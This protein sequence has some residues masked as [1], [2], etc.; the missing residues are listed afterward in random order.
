MY[1]L[2]LKLLFLSDLFYTV[3][4]LFVSVNSFYDEFKDRIQSSYAVLL[5]DYLSKLV[6]MGVLGILLYPKV[7]C[8][9]YC[10]YTDINDQSINQ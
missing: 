8:F 7:F 10:Y 3:M 4:L 5:Y 2:C 9:C 1:L 6:S